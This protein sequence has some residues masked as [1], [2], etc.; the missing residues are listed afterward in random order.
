MRAQGLITMKKINFKILLATLLITTSSS[1]AMEKLMEEHEVLSVFTPQSTI[2]TADDS[3]SSLTSLMMEIKNA[4]LEKFGLLEWSFGSAFDY[5][6]YSKQ[7]YSIPQLN[8]L[9]SKINHLDDMSK[10]IFMLPTTTDEDKALKTT[11]LENFSLALEDTL[12]LDDQILPHLDF[13]LDTLIS[14]KKISKTL[15]E[16]GYF[17]TKNAYDRLSNAFLIKL[18]DRVEDMY[19]R[20]RYGHTMYNTLTLETITPV[21]PYDKIV[22]TIHQEIISHHKTLAISR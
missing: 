2:T 7:H 3:Y 10:I 6:E 12:L 22:V 19:K 16:E 13:F 8:D 9:E 14:L 20:A 17:S 5:K 21:D 18:S 1:F 4:S 11:A 15:E